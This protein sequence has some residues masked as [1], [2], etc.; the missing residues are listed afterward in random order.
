MTATAHYKAPS[1]FD[2]VVNRAVRWLADRGVDL[3]GAQTLTVVGRRT[4][5]P[6]RVPVNVLRLDGAEY[7]VAVRGD[8]QW[9]RNARAAGTAELRRGRQRTVVALTE[10]DPAL[11]PPVIR[12]YLRRW[13]WEV[14]RFLPAGLEVSSS[15]DE[16]AAHAELIPVFTVIAAH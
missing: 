7:L 4:G 2:A 12:D 9:V 15:D 14:A 6:Q 8:T 11:R 5:T 16:L 1:G 13:G 3:A 10:V